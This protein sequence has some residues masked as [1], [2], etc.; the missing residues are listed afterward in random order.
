MKKDE[1]YISFRFTGE[2]EIGIDE[3]SKFLSNI[4]KSLKSIK[5]DLNDNNINMELKVIAIKN[6]S[7]KVIISLGGDILST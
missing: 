7:G 3:L 1:A 2:N 6:G 4:S 5:D